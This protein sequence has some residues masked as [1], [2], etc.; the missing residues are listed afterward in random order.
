MKVLIHAL[1]SR[2]RIFLAGDLHLGS[3]L[4]HVHAFG[5]MIRMVKEDDSARLVLMGDLLDAITFTDPRYSEEISS[6][7]VEQANAMVEMLRPVQEKILCILEGNH[8]RKLHAFGNITRDIICEA[9]NAPYGTYS[10]IIN[11]LD[12]NGNF[13]Y[14]LFVHHGFGTMNPQ[15]P[16]YLV[17]DTRVKEALKRKLMEKCGDAVIMAMGH[18][19]K[20]CV[21]EPQRNLFIRTEGTGLQSGYTIPEKSRGGFIHPDFRYY[22]GTGSFLRQ[23]GVGYSGYA[24]IAG[25]DPVD[26]GWVVVNVDDSWPNEVIKIY[27]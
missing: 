13:G 14:R 7:P 8:E 11:I 17:R 22:V 15:S 18:V 27:T 3:P 1:P 23:Y 19:H 6:T 4:A 9:L 25:Y 20:L 26:L 21:Y 2:H 16:S 5:R 10:S 12:Q 24:E